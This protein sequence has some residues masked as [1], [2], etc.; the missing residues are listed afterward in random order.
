MPF[1]A[2]LRYPGG[3][4]RLA[5]VV[6]RLLEENGLR[7]VHY[8]EPYAGGAAIAL[9]LLFGEYA[10]TVHINDLSRPVYAFWYAALHDPAE[11][12]RR[13]DR[14]KVT[15]REWRRQRSI[16]DR[17]DEADLNDLGF[18]T[19]F[20]NRANRSGIIQGGVIGGKDQSGKW[21]IDARFNKAELI[22]R[23][24]RIGRYATRINLYQLDA[25]E[26]TNRVLPQIGRNVLAFF[27]PPYI[28]KGE[29]LYLN[30]YEIEDHHRLAARVTKLE[31]PWIVTYDHAAIGQGL[32]LSHRRIVYGINY[33]A[34]DR[35]EGKEVMFLS[36]RLKLPRAWLPSVPIT[37]S[38]ERSEYPLYGIMETVKPPPK[39]E[40]G[41]QAADRFMKALKTVLSVPKSA[42]PNPFHKA[43]R[44]R[45][46]P[47]KG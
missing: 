38:A 5:T 43:A 29:K 17:R 21:G 10:S 16:Y 31:Q 37:M 11:L 1:H 42:V 12:C 39:M 15:M 18:A 3:K 46:K 32:Y 4:R 22:H 34:Q 14:T 7:D 41:P 24:E 2:P 13:I 26:F 9:A 36:N 30:D 27:D 8:V 47:V 33:S 19:L 45:K 44:K 35:Y 6:M 40:E 23:I 28:E 25:L 20:L